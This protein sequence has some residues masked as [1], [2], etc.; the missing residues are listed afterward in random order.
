MPRRSTC[1]YR[2]D[3]EFAERTL[4]SANTIAKRPPDI[5]R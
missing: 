1:L 4:E 3:R 2:R 5:S